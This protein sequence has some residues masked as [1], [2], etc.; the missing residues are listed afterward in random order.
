MRQRFD[1]FK[2]GGPVLQAGT[3][4]G[5]PIK[6]GPMEILPHLETTCTRFNTSAWRSTRPSA[7]P[8]RSQLLR[9]LP[10]LKAFFG[11][12]ALFSCCA[13]IGGHLVFSMRQG[14]TMRQG[15][16]MRQGFSMRQGFG[17]RQCFRMR[18][19][20]SMRQGF[21]MRQCFS[22]QQCF[23]M[24]LGFWMLQ[25]FCTFLSALIFLCILLASIFWVYLG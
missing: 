19:C 2:H 14:F 6:A 7:G 24:R 8:E 5:P 20:F 12:S 25:C 23:C 3:G 1:H 22:M 4:E 18:Q 9:I 13:N 17:T 16:G 10:S 11:V 15:F 21:G